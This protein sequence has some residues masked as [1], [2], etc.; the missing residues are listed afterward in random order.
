[1]KFMLVIS[2]SILTLAGCSKMS[3]SVQ[4]TQKISGNWTLDSDSRYLMILS[5]T[6]NE[7]YVAETSPGLGGGL[8]TNSGTWQIT[9]DVLNI[10]MS[11]SVFPKVKIP[12]EHYRIVSIDDHELRLLPVGEGKEL[13]FHK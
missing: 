12:I 10:A 7:C 9:N 13:G 4:M 6:A 2:I 5:Q 1:M 11:N 3:D 8:W